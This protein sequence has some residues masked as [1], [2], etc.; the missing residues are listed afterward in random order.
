MYIAD[1]VT[2]YRPDQTLIA[3]D[4]VRAWCSSLLVIRR[5]HI[6]LV[7]VVQHIQTKA[8]LDNVPIL[9]AS[10]NAVKTFT[11]DGTMTMRRGMGIECVLLISDE[12]DPYRAIQRVWF[13]DARMIERVRYTPSVQGSMEMFMTSDKSV[14]AGDVF[15]F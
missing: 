2:E 6:P 7:E 13:T 4:S 5:T 15:T 8:A 12:Q 3:V 11:T 1:I 9:V 10:T 14:E